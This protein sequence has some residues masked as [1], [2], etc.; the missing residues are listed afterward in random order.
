MLTK[1]KI[2][3]AAVLVAASASLAVA[4][5]ADPNLLNR[6]PAYNGAHGVG[7]SDEIVVPRTAQSAPRTFQSAPVGLYQGREINQAPL[8]AAGRPQ[9]HTF[10]YDSAPLISGGG[11]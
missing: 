6:Y 8:A 3:L 2:A 5:D 9:V 4:Q 11:Y 7:D 1:T 10:R